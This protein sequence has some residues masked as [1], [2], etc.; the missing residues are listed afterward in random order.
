MPE[1]LG[2]SGDGGSR[3]S[4]FAPLLCRFNEREPN[5]IDILS[6]RHIPAS[7]EL[8]GG[9]GQDPEI[10]CQ[11]PVIDIPR[12][13]L[14]PR[15]KTERMAA[16]HDGPTRDARSYVV[17]PRLI[18]RVLVEI[19]HEQRTRPNEAHLAADDIPELRKLIEAR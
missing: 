7:D 8:G 17:A 18:R 19:L 1:D 10:E 5:G 12:V 2:V 14:E 13:E 15:G 9:H 16:S 4:D 11:A 6:D 3:R